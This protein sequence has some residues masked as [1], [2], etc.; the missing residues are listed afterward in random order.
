MN[1]QGATRSIWLSG[2]LNVV[3]RVAQTGGDRVTLPDGTVWLVTMVMERW[4][5]WGR[6]ALTEQNGA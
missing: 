6:Y 1:I 4:A 3:N 5:D 2:V